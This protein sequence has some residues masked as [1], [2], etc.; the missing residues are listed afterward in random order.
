M[1]SGKTLYV[2]G[3]VEKVPYAD[4]ALG[5][6]FEKLVLHAWSLG[7]GTTWI[8]GTMKREAFECAA[9]LTAGEMMPC[10]SPI[11]YPAGKCSIK[12]ALLRRGVG[13][14]S[15]LPADRLCL[16]GAEEISLPVDRQTALSELIE[17]VRWA[18]SA[19]N[20]QPWRIV[21]S[22]RDFHFYE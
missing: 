5:Y 12:E 10:V 2:A 1:L 13:A 16:D 6:S 19:V 4:V 20:K 9:G 7:I 14:D 15:R 21:V 8:G 3:I 17:I 11:G 18:P 22:G